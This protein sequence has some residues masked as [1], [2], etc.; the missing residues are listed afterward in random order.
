MRR[1]YICTV[2]FSV[3]F[4]CVAAAAQSPPVPTG[5]PRITPNSGPDNS[6]AD[7]QRRVADMFNLER[8]LGA[9]RGPV[10]TP[11]PEPKLS[12][13]ER[14]RV[15]RLRRVAP[16]DLEAYSGV[17]K[18]EHT[19]VFKLFPDLGCISR[20]VVKVSDECEKFVP[21]SS[22]FTFRT[23]NYGDDIYHDIRFRDGRLSSNSFFS[24]GVITT[25][26]DEAV[27]AVGLAHP[28]LKF[29]T[30]LVPDTDPKAAATHARSFQAG[31]DSENFR[32]ADSV[33]ARENVTYAMRMIAY[34]LENTLKPM[35]AETTTNEMMFLSLPFDKRLDVIVVFRILRRD[36]SGGLT[37]V[38]KE[39]TRDGA[40][41]I[42][43]AR[44]Q[45]L[46]DFRPEQK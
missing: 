29:L 39:L 13:E 25:I 33:E 37:I 36:E 32:Y 26:G 10:K 23:N 11:P 6:D 17:L 27:D 16:S 18:Q 40:S 43:Y 14:E 4:L 24:Q 22:H 1:S 41:K 5:P 30:A 20:Q 45:A 31:I 38:W 7:F 15:L 12:S 34:R 35:S 42:K 46:K 8:K 3:L 9:I 44:N 21:L 28:A 2:L 19:G